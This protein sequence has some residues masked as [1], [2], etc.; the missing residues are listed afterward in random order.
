MTD[1]RFTAVVDDTEELLNVVDIDD[2][3]DVETLLMVLFA[4]PVVVEEVWNL[5]RAETSL[6]VVIQGNDE[7]IGSTFDFPLSVIGLVRSCAHTANDL[8]PY[9]VDASQADDASHVA[10]LDD[11]QL[12]TALQGAL[13]KVRL[14]NLMEAGEM[15]E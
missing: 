5:D 7:A 15:S 6:E 10:A 12:V 13:G 9:G 3:G 14:F 4:R 1:T 8:G 11:D 2:I